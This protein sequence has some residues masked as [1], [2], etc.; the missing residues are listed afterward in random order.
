MDLSGFHE[1]L[2]STGQ[3]AL[4]D[5]TAL[6]PTEAGYLAAFEKL[7]KRHAAELARS[8]LETV[9]L[10]TRAREKHSLADRLYF[11]REALEQ[12][13]SEA[14]SRHRAERF[15]A[16]PTVLDL[17]CGVGIDAIHLALAGCRVEAIDSDLLRLAMAEANA[18]AAGV[19]DRVRFHLGDVLSMVLPQ[20]EA[21]FVDP[22]RRDGEHRFLNPSRYQPPLGSVLAR[23]PAGF[24]FGAKIAP[25]VARN[26]LDT[27]IVDVTLRVTKPHAEREGYDLAEVEFISSAGELKECVLWFGPLKSVSRRAT[28]LPN[29]TLAADNP[30][31]DPTADAIREFLFDPD[32]SVIRAGLVGLLAEQLDAVAV[33]FGI[34]VLTGSKP[35]HSPFAACYSV[36]RSLPFKVETLREALRERGVGRVTILKRA[37]DVDVNAVLK[38]LKLTGSV[39]RHV[40]LTRSL[41]QVT[42]IVCD[43]SWMRSPSGWS[44]P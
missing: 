11:T 14:V 20:A 34:A 4:A 2:S 37:V 38:K 33:D 43:N 40:M 36:E 29:H 35:V 15:R 17:C 44:S 18:A 30:P 19:G 23:F 39:H 41:G 42:A 25:G 13:S 9:L 22:S 31:P 10:R 6:A 7:R 27:A 21:A 26:D 1:L 3:R 5:A 12:S 16:Y 28:L 24:P 32:S 8:A